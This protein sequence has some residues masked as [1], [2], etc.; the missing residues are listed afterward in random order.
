M[1]FFIL[2]ANVGLGSPAFAEVARV[3]PTYEVNLTGYNA[4]PAQTDSDPYTTA[5]GAY[6]NPR[7]VAARS[8]DLRDELPFGTVIA[9]LPTDTSSPNCGFPVVAD[10]VDLRVIADSMNPRIHNTV[11]ILFGSRDSVEVGG[12]TI[13]AARAL[14]ICED[15]KIEVMGKID[16]A[17]IPETQSELVAMLAGES[18]ELAF[19]K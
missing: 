16:I 7:I 4:V 5:S 13:N 14:G 17:D 18:P 1:G 12:R 15:V 3:L 6:S 11:D 19:A 9:I 2:P 8:V 10:R